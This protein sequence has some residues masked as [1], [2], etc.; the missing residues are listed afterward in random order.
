MSRVSWQF[1]S[2]RRK[3]KIDVFLRDTDTIKAAIDKFI[4]LKIVPP[5][6]LIHEYFSGTKQEETSSLEV[7]QEESTSTTENTI[8]QKRDEAD[9]DN[10]TS[11]YD[12]LIIITQETT[13]DD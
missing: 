11:Q 5:M 8:A 10:S 3:A 9:E 4:R 7:V 12:D 13:L 2:N 1:Y 6:D